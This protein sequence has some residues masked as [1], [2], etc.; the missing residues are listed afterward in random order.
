MWGQHSSAHNATA[1]LQPPGDDH[2]P[3][4][5]DTTGTQRLTCR[6]QTAAGRAGCAPP[7]SPP[8]C[9][10]GQQGYPCQ[11]GG[12]NGAYLPNE[13]PASTTAVL[14]MTTCPHG[15][16]HAA[17]HPSPRTRA[18][19]PVMCPACCHR[20][21]VGLTA[22][23][24]PCK[25]TVP[26]TAS[27]AAAAGHRALRP[28]RPPGV[29][30]PQPPSA[31]TRRGPSGFHGHGFYWL[32]TNYPHSTRHL[33]TTLSAV[34]CAT[35]TAPPTPASHPPHPP[36]HLRRR[37]V[38]AE[39]VHGVPPVRQRAYVGLEAVGLQRAAAGAGLTQGRRRAGGE[40][41]R[42]GL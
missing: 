9:V 6:C 32:G 13:P 42:G 24:P 19:A 1:R 41:G 28:S 2:S 16:L 8:A 4:A 3:T 22:S 40:E 38:R 10:R 5:L 23:P 31:R 18:P 21:A 35:C 17:P 39:S 34:S 33:V 30:A 11:Q 27:M 7:S 25:P 36:A 15:G 20:T 29:H 37:L 14:H 26:P 12:S